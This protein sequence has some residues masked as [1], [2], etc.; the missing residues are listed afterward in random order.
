[1]NVAWPLLLVAWVFALGCTAEV[2]EA[3]PAKI[4][5]KYSVSISRDGHIIQESV[6]MQVEVT[7]AEATV[8]TMRHVGATYI[9]L[10]FEDINLTSGTKLTICDG[11][12][13]QCFIYTGRGKRDLGQF[14]ARHVVGD[15][16]VMTLEKEQDDA[17][18]FLIDEYAAGYPSVRRASFGFDDR[19]NAICY[20]TSHPTE[21]AKV[22]VHSPH[23]ALT[24]DC[25]GTG[26][27]TALNQ[28]QLRVYGLVRYSFPVLDLCQ[29]AFESSRIM[30]LCS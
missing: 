14:W 13:D 18:T 11:N 9:A 22:C 29:A 15:T 1:M 19:Q 20:Q 6:P 26:Y 5:D 30:S 24:G 4:G 7:S 21:Y 23:L 27:S 8:F 2:L 25:V 28:R 3:G 16:V 10:H 17:G 12:D